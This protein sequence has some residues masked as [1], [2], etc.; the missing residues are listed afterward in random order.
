MWSRV[1][2]MLTSYTD[3]SY[4]SD[5][6]ARELSGARAMAIDIEKVSDDPP[7]RIAAWLST[8]ADSVLRGLDQQLLL[9]L[10]KIEADPARWRD[11]AET[12]V[13]H[14]EDLA[15]A[16]LTAPAFDLAAA[17]AVEASA[18]PETPRTAHAIRALERLGT[19]TFV[20]D[21]VAELRGADDALAAR[22]AGLCH[23][24]GPSIIPA[25]AELLSIEQDGRARLRLR[26]VLVG[27]GASGRESIQ[28]LLGA[29]NWEVRRTAAFLLRELGGTESL[30]SLEPLL[31]DTEP[32]VQREAIQGVVLSGSED[33]FALLVRVM[34]TAAPRARASL[35]HE[36]ATV[37]DERAAPLFAHLVR[38][39]HRGRQ[40]RG[41]EISLDALGAIGAGGG[42]DAIDALER[43]LHQGEWW[44]PARTRALRAKAAG[45]AAPH[46]H[47]G[48]A[49]GCSRRRRPAGRAARAPP[50][51]RSSTR[52][53]PGM[54]R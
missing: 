28:Q 4:V 51:G 22:V 15:R 23:A 47:R 25:L 27:F 6:Y 40:R 20:R 31:R 45:R 33:A 7:E 43:A 52:T 50:R 10:L 11:I 54:T 36:L 12:V 41:Y 18:T 37:R 29:S 13:G 5:D 19:G 2:T 17:V 34:T 14:V 30:S 9:D 1:E 46:R 3:E 26:D 38:H 48:R 42:P 53:Q 49:G 8:V 24:I 16:G 21:A 32:L 35:V 44:A 39:L